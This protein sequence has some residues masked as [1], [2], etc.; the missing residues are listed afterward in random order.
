LWWKENERKEKG[1]GLGVDLSFGFGFMIFMIYWKE[2]GCG[3]GVFDFSGEDLCAL[4]DIFSFYLTKFMPVDEL[5]VV[6]MLV[7]DEFWILCFF[8]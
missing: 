4:D 8:N 5:L 3:L 1:C 7:L 6:F 2:K